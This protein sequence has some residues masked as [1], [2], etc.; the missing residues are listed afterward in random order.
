MY[1]EKTGDLHK[2]KRG[3]IEEAVIVHICDDSE[4]F[5]IFVYV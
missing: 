1:V 2:V 3:E 5:E 4:Y